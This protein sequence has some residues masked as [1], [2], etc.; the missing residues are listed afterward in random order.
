MSE[1]PLK[2]LPIAFGKL[3]TRL[4]VELNM[5][6]DTLALA[7]DLPDTNAVMAMEQGEREPTLTELFRIANALRMPH[8]I[9]FVDIVEAW[10]HDPTDHGV[11]TS[12]ASDFA[13]LYRLGCYQGHGDFREHP[14]TFYLLDQATAAART[15]NVTRQSKR[16]PLLNTVLTYVRLG[17][18]TFRADTD[19][20]QP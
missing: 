6:Q 16:L 4:R 5:T 1:D 11:Y 20:G 12:R 17:S 7:T 15:L 13:Q 2:R 10:R 14:T 3:L 9:L 8:A 19:E 18:L